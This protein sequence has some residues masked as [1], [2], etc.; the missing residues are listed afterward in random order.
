MD[1]V[2]GDPRYAATGIFAG[3]YFVKNFYRI[4]T[5]WR[6]D[7]CLFHGLFEY[8][9]QLAK[10]WE[11]GTDLN[12]KHDFAGVLTGR[13]IQ[14]NRFL[15]VVEHRMVDNFPHRRRFGIL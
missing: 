5:Q 6:F 8:A 11:T 1:D 3:I 14:V 12:K 13:T 4:V 7:G 9:L 2:P 10:Q 15:H